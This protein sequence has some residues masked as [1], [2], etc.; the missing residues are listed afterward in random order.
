MPMPLAT[1]DHFYWKR[2]PD[3]LVILPIADK[4]KALS[5]DRAL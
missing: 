3:L 1:P 2:L 5:D 4:E